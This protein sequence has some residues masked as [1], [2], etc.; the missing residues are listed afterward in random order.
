[1][2]NADFVDKVSTYVRQSLQDHLARSRPT[3]GESMRRY[4]TLL[5]SIHM[6]YGINCK[7]V[8]N[9]FCQHILKDVAGMDA[10][11]RDMLDTYDDDD[12]EVAEREREGEMKRSSTPQKSNSTSSSSSSSSAVSQ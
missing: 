2:A 8:E 11:L 12:D 5:L 1:M 9:L 10:L 3:P 7:M 6:L 4:S